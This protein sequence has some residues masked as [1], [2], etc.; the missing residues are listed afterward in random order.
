MIL[1]MELKIFWKVSAGS[2]D[3]VLARTSALVLDDEGIA[4]VTVC[5]TIAVEEV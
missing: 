1:S 5:H 4:P 3:E 2:I